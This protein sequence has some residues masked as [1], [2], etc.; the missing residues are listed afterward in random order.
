MLGEF[1]NPPETLADVLR[2]N[3]EFP[4]ETI[5]LRFPDPECSSDATIFGHSIMPY[6]GNHNYYHGP[7]HGPY[8]NNFHGNSSSYYHHYPPHGFGPQ[9]H[10]NGPPYYHGFH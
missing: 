1:R 9:P 5:V 2:V 8:Y 10:Y 6:Y 7:G 4:L 3:T